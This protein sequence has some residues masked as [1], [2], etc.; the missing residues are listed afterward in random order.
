MKNFWFC[1]ERV[2][3]MYGV[4]KISSEQD[5]LLTT[6]PG[7]QYSAQSLAEHLKVFAEA[8]IVVDMICQSAPRG[9]SVDFSFTTSY[10]NFAAVMKAIPAAAK[11]NPPLIS[12][13]YSKIN[14]F[15]EEMVISCGVAARALAALAEAGVEIALIT[16]SDLDISLLVRQQDEDAALNALTAAFEL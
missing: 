8:G 1:N 7:A 11:A 10:D 9:D 4:S 16:T 3:N 2:T 14:L 13:G 12:G 15:G 5:I 6:F